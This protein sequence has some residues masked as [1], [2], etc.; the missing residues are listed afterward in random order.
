MPATN[1]LELYRGEIWDRGIA[2]I[3]SSEIQEI[4]INQYFGQNGL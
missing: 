4:A 3:A 1:Y 2:Y